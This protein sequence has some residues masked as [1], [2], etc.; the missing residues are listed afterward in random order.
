[1]VGNLSVPM[2]DNAD[3]LEPTTATGYKVG[4]KKTLEEL[5]QLDAQDGTFGSSR[6]AQEMERV[7]WSW[8]RCK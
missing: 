5:A 7:S 3:D 2:A 6:V 8:R 1:M 4:D